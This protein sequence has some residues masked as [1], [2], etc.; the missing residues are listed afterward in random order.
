MRIMECSKLKTVI[1]STPLT[2]LVITLLFI[3]L[4]VQKDIAHSAVFKKVDFS[5]QEYS[6]AE[7]AEFLSF[8]DITAKALKRAPEY[9]N[10]HYQNFVDSYAVRALA[11]AYDITGRERYMETC[12]AWSDRMLQYQSRMIPEGAYYIGY[13]REPGETTGQW[14]VAD[15]GSIVMGILAT[16]VRCENETDKNRYLNSARSFAELV[17]K[18]FIGDAGGVTP[19]YWNKSDKEWWCSTALFS[20]FAF[21]MYGITGEEKYKKVGIEAVD[22]LLQFEYDQTILYSFETGAPTTIF[23]IL[24]AY[25]AGLP[26]LKADSKRQKEVFRRFSQTAE[27]IIDN[28]NKDGWWDYDPD[29][30]GVKLNGF[31]CHLMI[32]LR[33]AHDRSRRQLKSVS[34]S[35]NLV[36]FQNLIINANERALKYLAAKGPQKSAFNQQMAF[37]MM[38]YA[39]R[40]CP[41]ELYHKTNNEFLYKKYSEQELIQLLKKQ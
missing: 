26:Y 32:Y 41:D 35:G 37:A 38:S 10:A 17:M 30:W 12:R 36:S 14:F 1:V 28:Q 13:F 7:L 27:W 33:H 5:S 25:A 2:S 40:F 6:E 34:H 39:E 19:G 22:W 24:E 29:N 11:V 18:N 21:Q 8:S 9:G 31:P 23:Y 4:L 20:A 3:T 15:C 16:A